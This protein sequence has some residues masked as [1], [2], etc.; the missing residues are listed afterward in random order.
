MVVHMLSDSD[1]INTI[2]GTF[3]SLHDTE[4][5]FACQDRI[6][7][8]NFVFIFPFKESNSDFNR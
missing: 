2:I 7:I 4:L 5:D 3:V 6:R 1:I 8:Y